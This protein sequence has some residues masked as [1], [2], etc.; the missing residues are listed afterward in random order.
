MVGVA[1][2]PVLDVAPWRDFSAA[3]CGA[4]EALHQRLGWDVW[5]VT[6]VVDDRQVVV[7]AHPPDVIRPGT[8][9]PWADTFCRAMVAGEAPRA[10][11]VTA[12]VPAFAKR[13]TGPAS[14]IGAYIGVPIVSPEGELFGTLCAFGFRARPRGAARDLPLVEAVAR[15]L[16]TL[17]AAGM[18][19]SDPPALRD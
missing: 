3:A 7:H 10:A 8:W 19:P 2:P 5:V 9:L 16:S 11:T 17:I 18:T 6:R 4:L 13:R 12:A 15:L 14:R 1:T